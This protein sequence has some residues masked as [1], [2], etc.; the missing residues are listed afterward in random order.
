[1]LLLSTQFPALARMVSESRNANLVQVALRDILGVDWRIRC[2]EAGSDGPAVGGPTG[3]VQPG[4]S[5]TGSPEFAGRAGA[6]TQSKPR[7]TRAAGHTAAGAAGGGAES[8]RRGGGRPSNGTDGSGHRGGAEHPPD[9]EPDRAAA[10]EPDEEFNPYSEIDPDADPA[11]TPSYEVHDPS[12]IAIAI[13]TAKLG[14]R[15]LDD[16]A[17]Q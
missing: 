9:E 13:L 14:A 1:M 6:D 5:H 7:D 12:K 11:D 3:A 16:A 10:A 2:V 15:P 17:D 8:G 4:G